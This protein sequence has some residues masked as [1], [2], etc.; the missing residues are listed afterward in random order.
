[1]NFGFVLVCWDRLAG[2]AVAPVGARPSAPGSPGRPVPIEQ[3]AR[4]AAPH[5]VMAQMLQPFRLRAATDGR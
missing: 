5:L 3:T 4:G 2:C 1:M